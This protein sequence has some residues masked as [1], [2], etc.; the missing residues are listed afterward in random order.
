MYSPP[1][2]RR[3]SLGLAGAHARQVPTERHIGTYRD[4]LRRH[5]TKA[6]AAAQGSKREREQFAQCLLSRAGDIRNVMLAVEHCASRGQAAGPNGLRPADLDTTARWN[7]ARVLGEVI[8][9]GTFR[10]GEART[11]WIEQGVH[12][13]RSVSATRAFRQSTAILVQEARLRSVPLPPLAYAPPEFLQKNFK[14]IAKLREDTKA[15]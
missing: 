14:E 12:F 15:A 6:I 13:T 5:E 4:F 8:R 2:R 11:K 1:D 9:N 10:P 7:L 3:V